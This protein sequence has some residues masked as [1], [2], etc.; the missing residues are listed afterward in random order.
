MAHP[1]GTSAVHSTI[2]RWTN[3]DP[4][5]TLS[6]SS[7]HTPQL[8]SVKQNLFPR[9]QP[10][11]T[12]ASF[13]A[14]MNNS[15][16]H[17]LRAI[18]PWGT[19]S[20]S[21][22]S[23]LTASSPNW[24]KHPLTPS[25]VSLPPLPV[26]YCV[27]L[28]LWKVFNHAVQGKVAAK[29]L[30]SLHQGPCNVAECLLD[31]RILA[32]ESGWNEEALQGVF[33]N[34]FSELVKGKLAVKDESVSLDRLISLTI[35]LGNRMREQHRERTS[36]SQA[37]QADRPSPRL[38]ANLI[39]ELQ[40][41]PWVPALSPLPGEDLLGLQGQNPRSEVS[42]ATLNTWSCHSTSLMLQLSSKLWSMMNSRTSWTAL[43]LCI[44]MTSWF[45]PKTPL[46]TPTMSDK[47]YSDS[48]RTAFSSK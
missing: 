32:A 35:W 22:P 40:S 11:P 42:W 28:E 4:N 10:C 31:F 46:S 19:M 33:L 29:H 15:S 39:H 13:L 25:Q 2:M 36:Q 12:M 41:S 45:S 48:W 44:W 17:S 16:V 38:L 47:S 18:K 30:L 23:N 1:H 7:P 43:S 9:I 6:H 26:R 5:C 37:S 27:T 20:G 34:G 21:S 3:R 14:S 24:S 8:P